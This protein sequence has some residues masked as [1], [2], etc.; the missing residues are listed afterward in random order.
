MKLFRHISSK[1]IQTM[2]LVFL[3][4]NTV[5][6]APTLLT[7]EKDMLVFTQE[8]KAFDDLVI[9]FEK[10]VESEDELEKI[11]PERNIYLFEKALEVAR[12]NPLNNLVHYFS[13]QAPPP[14]WNV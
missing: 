10:E 2:L 7:I 6:E 1:S 14:D 12:F 9:E 8:E 5:F 3:A 11:A 4:L 13:I